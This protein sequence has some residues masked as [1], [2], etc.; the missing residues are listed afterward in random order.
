MIIKIIPILILAVDR[1]ELAFPC[2]DLF[3][4]GC[5]VQAGLTFCRPNVHKV[6]VRDY[7][8][9]HS[10]LPV[11]VSVC[12]CLCRSTTDRCATEKEEWFGPYQNQ[13]CT[14]VS[15]LKS[16]QLHL[17]SPQSVTGFLDFFC[18]EPYL[19]KL[20]LTQLYVHASVYSWPLCCTSTRRGRKY[21]SLFLCVHQSRFSTVIMVCQNVSVH[22][23][24]DEQCLNQTNIGSNKSFMSKINEKPFCHAILWRIKASH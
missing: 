13:S 5:E 3:V 8:V 23:T 4:F 16:S 20:Y 17:Y 19:T 1:R 9:I 2:F 12:T 6:H 21:F 24:W 18:L 15:I 22:I 11:C 10:Y 7:R 14:E